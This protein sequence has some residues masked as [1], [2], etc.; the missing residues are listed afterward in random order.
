MSR[1]HSLWIEAHKSLSHASSEK[2]TLMPDISFGGEI[3]YRNYRLGYVVLNSLSVGK[4][5]GE[6][7]R[8]KKK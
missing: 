3:D 5:N 8:E 1:A 7:Q 2:K 4:K 6:L